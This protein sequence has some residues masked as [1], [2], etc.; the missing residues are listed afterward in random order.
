VLAWASE[1][2][3]ELKAGCNEFLQQKNF[4]EV[5]DFD[6]EAGE[7]VLK[8]V[9]VS[10]LPKSIPRKATEALSNLRHSF[11]QALFAACCA[12]GKRPK[13]SIYFPWSE[14]PTDL[15]YRLGAKAKP[16]KVPKS[17]IPPELWPVLRAF[18]PYGRS[19]THTGGDDVIRALAQIANRKHTVSLNFSGSVAGGSYPSFKGDVPAGK[20]FSLKAPHWDTVKNEIEIARFPE[21]LKT[22]YNYR[23][24]LYVAFDEAVP[25]R[26]LPL[27]E[28]LTAFAA[29]AQSIVDG[30]EGEA[31]KIAG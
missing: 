20:T 17:K 13:D 14:T 22:D 19:D 1:A 4:R 12:I 26:G 10:K 8:I 6:S 27:V 24:A 29:K 21:E 15:E 11:D 16:S 3:D 2:I 9:L 30:L 28:S 23:L 5:R 25:L 31:A 7:N 18:E